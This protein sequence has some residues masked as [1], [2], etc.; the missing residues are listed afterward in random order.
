MKPTNLR[1][2]E[3]FRNLWQIELDQS[4]TLETALQP[5]FWAH[6]ARRLRPLAEIIVYPHDF[7]WRA[8]LLVR[9]ASPLEARV[10]VLH[11]VDL[12]KADQKAREAAPADKLS[13]TWRTPILKYCVVKADK[14]VVESGFE[15]KE[16]AEAWIRDPKPRVAAAA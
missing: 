15:T 3:H 5:S 9:S 14:T 12:V 7:S 4:E 8:V 1:E 13:A 6:V 10:V 2:A 11:H 16:E